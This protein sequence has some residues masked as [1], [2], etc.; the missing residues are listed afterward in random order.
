MTTIHPGYTVTWNE[1]K[2]KLRADWETQGVKLT[3]SET[4]N[5]L[6]LSL[7]NLRITSFVCVTS[8]ILRVVLIASPTVYLLVTSYTSTTEWIRTA[9][10]KTRDRVG[11]ST[12]LITIMKYVN[13]FTEWIANSTRHRRSWMYYNH[14]LR[15]QHPTN[16]WM[17]YTMKYVNSIRLNSK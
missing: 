16:T 17:N 9:S 5:K 4:L 2:N 13:G 14:K 6:F 10:D 11:I 7:V 1:Y 12:E 3:I 8:T 15:K